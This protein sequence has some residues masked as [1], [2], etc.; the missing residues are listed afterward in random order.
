MGAKYIYGLGK[1]KKLG[2]Y[3]ILDGPL[4]LTVLEIFILL[5]YLEQLV[6]QARNFFQCDSICDQLHFCRLAIQ[7]W[8]M[9][10]WQILEAGS[11]QIANNY[12]SRMCT[13][14]E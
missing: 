14:A 9:L 8:S 5:T 3:G 7:P 1:L 2:E 10:G 12:H 13:P 4:Y 11:S 6:Q